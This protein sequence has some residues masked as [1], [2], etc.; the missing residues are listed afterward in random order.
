MRESLLF[1]YDRRCDARS[2]TQY[3]FLIV[4]R[5]HRTSFGPVSFIDRTAL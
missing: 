4:S 3:A 1:L 2:L 5:K